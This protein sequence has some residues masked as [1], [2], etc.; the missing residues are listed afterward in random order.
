MA[1]DFTG[2]RQ[3]GT[4]DVVLS[5]RGARVAAA[6]GGS[7]TVQAEPFSEIEVD[8]SPRWEA[9]DID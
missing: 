2:A 6:H 7:V 4:I 9:R 1:V 5:Q 3:E 8:L